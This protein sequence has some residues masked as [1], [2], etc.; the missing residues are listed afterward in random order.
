MAKPPT[1]V[2]PKMEPERQK[3]WTGARTSIRLCSKMNTRE[4]SE[5]CELSQVK[6]SG[7]LPSPAQIHGRAFHS[8]NHDGGTVSPYRLIN[9]AIHAQRVAQRLCGTGAEI[10]HKTKSRSD[11]EHHTRSNQLGGTQIITP[12]KDQ[13]PESQYNQKSHVIQKQIEH[14]GNRHF[15]YGLSI[16]SGITDEN[17]HSTDT[18]AGRHNVD[19][20]CRGSQQ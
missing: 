11:G 6:I 16:A 19:K 18:C 8:D 1:M 13:Q 3:K 12:E 14:T 2:P 4:A 17:S 7:H 20:R 10:E 15:A 9:R 5:D